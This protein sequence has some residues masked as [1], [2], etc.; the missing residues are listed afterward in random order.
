MFKEYLVGALVLVMWTTA[1]HASELAP[2]PALAEESEIAVRLSFAEATPSTEIY[3]EIGEAAG[4][5]V[6]FGPRFSERRIA[7]EIDTSRTSEAL[8]LVAAAAGDLWVPTVANAIIVADDTP[9]NHREYEPVVIRTFVLENGSVREADKVLRSIAGVTHLAGNE[10]LRTVTVREPAA[11]VPI[12]ERLIA[13]LDRAPGEIDARIELLHLSPESAIDPPPARFDSDAY[14]DW[15]RTA[16]AKVLADST[17]GLLGNRH[18]NLHLGAIQSPDMGLDLR[19]DGIV[20]PQ[21]S[22]V[23]LDIRLILH[24]TS[25]RRSD[26]EIIRSERGRIETSA[27]LG[28]GSTLLL[29]IPGPD[30]GGIAIAITPT[31]VRGTEFES[32]EIEAVWVGSESRIHASR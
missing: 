5:E 27:R 9:Q 29:R 31:I 30:T 7:V 12:I 18:A 2:P 20:H 11:K 19:L 26:G 14:H 21:S 17:L 13:H 16:G 3:R 10:D 24:A 4:I 23:S 8:D 28:S 32:S 22:D 1:L 25:R 6:L 15:R